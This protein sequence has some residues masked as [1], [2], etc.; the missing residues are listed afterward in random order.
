MRD[1]ASA[2]PW[3]PPPAGPGRRSGRRRARPT[4]SSARCRRTRRRRA[5]SRWIRSANCIAGEPGR[6]PSWR[7]T[8]RLLVLVA[9]PHRLARRALR[10]AVARR[11]RR[12]RAPRSRSR[13]LDV[14]DAGLDDVL[15]ADA[16]AAAHPGPLRR[17]RRADE[18]PLRADLPVVRGG[19]RRAARACRGRV[20][21]K[22]ASDPTGAVRDARADPH[23]PAL[24]PGPAAAGRHGRRSPTTTSPPPAELG[25]T[26]AAGL[27]AGLW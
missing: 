10:D 20:V 14:A 5:G 21:A 3:P 27:D 17:P 18:G 4:G 13:L 16:V 8:K 24:A 11:R 12:G 7:P 6:L 26:L 25:A 23:R 2:R 22:G 15:G 19:A 1:E 9:L